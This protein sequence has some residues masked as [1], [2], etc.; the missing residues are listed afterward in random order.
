LQILAQESH[1]ESRAPFQGISFHETRDN[2]AHLGNLSRMETEN[3]FHTLAQALRERLTVIADH[4]GRWQN[5]SEHLE[6]LKAASEKITRLQSQLPP[7][8]PSQL[9]HFLEG[10]SYD[11]ALAFLDRM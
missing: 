6:R 7:R 3:P 9:A 1:R 4:Q 2:G 10:C 8:I 5:P 11:K